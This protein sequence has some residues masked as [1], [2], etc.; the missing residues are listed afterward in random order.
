MEAEFLAQLAQLARTYDLRV[1]HYQPGVVTRRADYSEV[2]IE[3]Q[4]EGTYE[5]LSRFVDQ[6][7]HLPRLSS[8]TEMEIQSQP[9][10][11]MY[12]FH[13]KF[14][15]YFMPMNNKGRGASS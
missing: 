1:A 13:L 3:L 15:V 4:G 6:I 5:G 9:E 7:P 12:S 8:V 11:P 2:Q 10:K 14:S